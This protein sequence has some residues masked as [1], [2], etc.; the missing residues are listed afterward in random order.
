MTRTSSDH[1]ASVF[2]VD[3]QASLAEIR[4][5]DGTLVVFRLDPAPAGGAR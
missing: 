3:P 5:H 4:A 1:R 2:P